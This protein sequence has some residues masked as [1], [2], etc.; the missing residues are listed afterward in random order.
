MTVI[1]F[2]S[3]SSSYDISIGKGVLGNIASLFNVRRKVLV[4][5]D[6]GVPAEYPQAVMSACPDSILHTV[7]GG[8]AFKSLATVEGILSVLLDNGFTRSDAVIAVGGGM[9]GD[10]AG[11]AAS[12]YQRGIDFCNV[13]TTLLSQVDASVGGKTAV[14]FKGVK[15]SVGAFHNPSAVIIDTGTHATLGPRLF[16]EGMAE[17]VKMAATS[18]RAL[19]ERIE[20]GRYGDDIEGVISSALAIKVSVVT[21]DPS[22]KGLRAVLNFGHTIG[23]AIEALCKG[24]LYHGECVAAGMMYMCS[25]KV[26]ERLSPVL[27][28]LGLPLS[29][30]YSA[31]EIMPLVMHDKKRRAGGVVRCVWVEEIGSFEFRDLTSSELSAIIEKRK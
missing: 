4:V 29:D 5:T 23:H 18:D 28:K 22:E 25:D 13:P 9:V 31:S 3:A 17:V 30:P 10:M 7:P 16:A 19:F 24:S 12:C 14:N 26:R 8:E 27:Q 2:R 11:F 20:S 6:E 15:N 21:A 1:P